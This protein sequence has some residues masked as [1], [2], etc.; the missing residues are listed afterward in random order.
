MSMAAPPSAAV[1]TASGWIALLQEP[2]VV[3]RSNA[4]KK[5]LEYVDTLWH[6]V[7]ESLPDLE[8]IA[9]DFNLPLPMS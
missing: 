2:D 1:A 6:N 8:I 4:L 3:L 9:E 5:L 7:A